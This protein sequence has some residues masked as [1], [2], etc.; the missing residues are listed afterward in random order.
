YTPV[1]HR[2][3]LALRSAASKRPYNAVNDP[4]Y[5]AEVEMWRPG[6]LIPSADTV[7]EDVRRLYIGYAPLVRKYFEVCI[8]V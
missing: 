8:S 6:T 5:Q 4:W 1:R 3:I 2:T 7:A